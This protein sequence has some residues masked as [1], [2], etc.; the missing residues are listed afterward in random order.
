MA[1]WRS[2]SLIT[3]IFPLTRRWN[4]I[5]LSFARLSSRQA[6]ALCSRATHMLKKASPLAAPTCVGVRMPL[7]NVTFNLYLLGKTQFSDFIYDARSPDDIIF[8]VLVA[9]FLFIWFF[10]S[11]VVL[12]VFTELRDSPPRCISRK[13]YC[14]SSGDLVWILCCWEK[15]ARKTGETFFE[16]IRYQRLENLPP[17]STALMLAIH[18][19]LNNDLSSTAGK[20][21]GPPLPC[22]SSEVSAVSPAALSR[23]ALR[24]GMKRGRLSKEVLLVRRE[25]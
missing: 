23:A 5:Q 12:V 17:S 16:S 14:L 11:F 6:G 15:H 7:Q 2:A 24:H 10:C 19:V 13:C 3:Q 22:C 18:C 8:E 20:E 9:V 1:T 4:C 21:T 25:R